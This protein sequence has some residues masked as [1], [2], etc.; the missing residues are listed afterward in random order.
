MEKKQKLY[1]Y[2][3]PIFSFRLGLKNNQDGTN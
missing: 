3:D 1:L 2:K